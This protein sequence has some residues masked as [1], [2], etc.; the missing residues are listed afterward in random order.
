VTRFGISRRSSKASTD[1]QDEICGEVNSPS[2]D[3]NRFG[4]LLA[5]SECLHSMERQGCMHLETWCDSTLGD[6]H[7][8]S[9]ARL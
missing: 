8:S 9:F 1:T 7:A 2:R 6:S 3:V 4:L 5:L